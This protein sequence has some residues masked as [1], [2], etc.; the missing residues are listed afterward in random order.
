MISAALKLNQDGVKVKA[1]IVEGKF[2]WHARNEE[3]H[4]I[5]NHTGI[6][7]PGSLSLVIDLGMRETKAMISRIF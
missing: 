6:N 1:S 2:L 5:Y 4:I 7:C 3:S